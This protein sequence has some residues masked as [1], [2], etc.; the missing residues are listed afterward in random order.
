M[1]RSDHT[2]EG[3]EG[4][5]HPA[6]PPSRQRERNAAVT[7]QRLLEAAER[8]F[9]ARGFAGARLRAIAAAADVQSALIH[10]YFADKQGL[11][12]AVVDRALLPTSTE[13]WTLL[14]SCLDLEGL[15][16]GFVDL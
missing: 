3:Q 10:H 6:P 5:S 1:L 8:E 11:Y 15:F 2:T 9:A 7:R 14:G 12:R 13:S 4:A 16:T